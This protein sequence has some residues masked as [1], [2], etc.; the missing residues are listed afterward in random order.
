M[1]LVRLFWCLIAG[2]NTISPFIHL[3]ESFSDQ[4][5]S[6]LTSLDFPTFVYQMRLFIQ[7]SSAVLT[8]YIKQ[9]LLSINIDS[10]THT[11]LHRSN[12]EENK[13]IISP[14]R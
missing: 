7:T 13:T 2:K 9:V 12:M 14:Q 8:G 3:S 1:E 6:S 11:H 4:L 5:P 10:P